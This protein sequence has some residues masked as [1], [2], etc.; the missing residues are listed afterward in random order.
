[1]I[2]TNLLLKNSFKKYIEKYNH[3]FIDFS[4]IIKF[5]DKNF[6]SIKGGH[7]SPDT[8]KI[9]SNELLKHLN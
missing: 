5:N 3:T 6:Y 4:E 2:K 1:M 8:Y 9:I 7:Y